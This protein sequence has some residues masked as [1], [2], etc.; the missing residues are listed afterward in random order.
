M[1]VI[2]NQKIKSFNN[3]KK[4]TMIITDILWKISY[5]LFVSFDNDWKKEREAGRQ[6]VVD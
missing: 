2:L 6:T 1:R 4:L 3:K 5:F